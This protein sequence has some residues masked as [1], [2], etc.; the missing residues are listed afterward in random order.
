MNGL[1]VQIF[2]HMQIVSNVMRNEHA[3]TANTWV[4]LCIHTVWSVS[5]FL[6]VHRDNTMLIGSP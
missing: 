4:S 3:T 1:G 6:M 5:S 2:K